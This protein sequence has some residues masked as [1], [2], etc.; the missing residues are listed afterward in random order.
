MLVYSR[1]MKK[2]GTIHLQRTHGLQIQEQVPTCVI[3][4]KG[5]L[6]EGNE[7]MCHNTKEWKENCS[8]TTQ[9]LSR[10]TIVVQSV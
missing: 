10:S 4:T 9:R 2:L 3:Q 1:K 7:E 5:C 8:H 6:K